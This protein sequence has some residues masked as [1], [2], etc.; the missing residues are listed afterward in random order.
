MAYVKRIKYTIADD[1]E[2]KQDLLAELSESEVV[3]GG[4]ARQLVYYPTPMS[5]IRWGRYLTPAQ[6]DKYLVPVDENG[7]NIND[8]NIEDIGI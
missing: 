1:N 5:K 3:S 8:D 7:S 2:L 6:I 4:K